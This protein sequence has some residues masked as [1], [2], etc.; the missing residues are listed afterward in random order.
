[1]SDDQ[2]RPTDARPTGAPNQA[3]S[4]AAAPAERREA[5][6]PPAGAPLPAEHG[7]ERR[8]CIV[9]PAMF[10]AH[11]FKYLLIAVLFLGGLAGVV[12]SF[13]AEPST[14]NQILRWAGGLVALAAA[15]WWT[16]W[17]LS[18]TVAIR[19]EITNKRTIRH[20]GIV[21]RSS[22]EVLHDHVRS[23]DIDQSVVQ[24]ILNTGFI[25]IDSAGQDDIEI[26]IQDVPTP[27]RIKSIIDRY[28]EM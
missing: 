26:R 3:A 10:R 11:P 27:Y 25:G 28:R 8:I 6:A 2:T 9:R 21:R 19:L 12:T 16:T 20:E 17:W 24:R 5:G 13:I 1:M 22:T 4:G 7:P 15:V 14:T 23:V 18:A